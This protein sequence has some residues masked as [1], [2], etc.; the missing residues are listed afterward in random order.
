MIQRAM[1]FP[2]QGAQYPGMGK[3]FCEA[4][5]EADALFMRANEVLGFDLKSICF[6]GPEEQVNRTDICQPGILTTSLAILEVLKT[7][8][9]LDPKLF[10]ATA[11]L[12]LGEYTA[13][14][15]ADVLDFED[16]VSLVA[17]RG[18]YMQDD[19]AKAP[20]GMMTLIGATKE[21][22]EEICR[23]A[24]SAGII[25]AANFLGPNQIAVSGAL[26]ALDRAETMLK[27]LNVKRG[28]RLKVSGAF[29]SPFMHDGGEKLKMELERAAFRPPVIPFASNVS[30]NFVEDSE[31]IREHLGR[32]VTS[33]VYW[34]DTMNRFIDRGISI[35]YEPGPGKVLS[36]IL[37]KVDRSLITLTL[38]DPEEIESFIEG[39]KES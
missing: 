15:F 35:F 22:A 39:W 26:E 8:H 34:N 9:G 24:S 37:K 14:V 17:K 27:D 38:D 23:R 28:I 19:S 12:S 11:G 32:Q 31:E 30:G 7:R 18:R 20:S 13:L 21:A 16:A 10:H 3:S 25:V 29:H 4:F 5:P 36:G 33:P 1:L 6:N 2:G